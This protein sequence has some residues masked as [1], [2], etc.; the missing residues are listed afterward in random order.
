MERPGWHQREEDSWVVARLEK[1]DLAPKVP[2]KILTLAELAAYQHSDLRYADAAH[3]NI[4]AVVEVDDNTEDVEIDEEAAEIAAIVDMP[5]AAAAAAEDMLAAEDMPAVEDAVV[6]GYT[7]A[8]DNTAEHVAEEAA[9]TAEGTVVDSVEYTAEAVAEGIAGGAAG[10][11]TDAVETEAAG[12]N[13]VADKTAPD[14]G[15]VAVAA[16]LAMQPVLVERH[17]R[18]AYQHY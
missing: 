11:D 9:C 6:A 4:D 5:A 3:G 15:T 12:N 13:V 14:A 18:L 7:A 8:V 10:T 1:G 17:T 2:Q 16:V